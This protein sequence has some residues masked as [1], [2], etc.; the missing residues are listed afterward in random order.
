MPRNGSEQITEQ[1][2]HFVVPT[3][4]GVP[5]IGGNGREI[6]VTLVLERE[7]ESGVG[8]ELLRQ[9]EIGEVARSHHGGVLGN[10]DLGVE[11][12]GAVDEPDVDSS[13]ANLLDGLQ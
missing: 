5:E 1:G 11:S 9:S 4:P 7:L 13:V 6:P 12:P 3:L 10:I 8:F 2:Q